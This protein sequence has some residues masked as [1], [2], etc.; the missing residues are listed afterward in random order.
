M[1][2]NSLEVAAH[3]AS[4]ATAFAAVFG[5]GIAFYQ[6]RTSRL[7]AQEAT[8]TTLFNQALHLSLQYPDL[9]NASVPPADKK[10]RPSYEWFMASM[11]LSSE[12][13]LKIT[14]GDDAWIQSIRENLEA[15]AAYFEER[16]SSENK[17]DPYYTTELMKIVNGIVSKHG[18]ATPHA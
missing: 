6:V 7:V 2:T 11:L 10:S 1:A 17:L 16:Q 18:K 9:A 4:L 3:W 15:H 5:L 12:E 8:A 13:I 14:G